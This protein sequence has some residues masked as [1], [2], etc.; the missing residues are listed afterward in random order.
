MRDWEVTIQKAE[1][2]KCNRCWKIRP[3]VGSLYF[4]EDLCYQCYGVIRG[5]DLTG[6]C[7]SNG[8]RIEDVK[9]G[10]EVNE[11]NLTRAYLKVGS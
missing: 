3:E 9:K 11:D 6:F 4:F 10:I 7:E 8:L 1:G 5:M 2:K